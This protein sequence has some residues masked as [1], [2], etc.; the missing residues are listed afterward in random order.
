[1]TTRVLDPSEYHR[2]TPTTLG[3]YVSLLPAETRVIVIEQDGALVGH[4]AVLP[5]W[6][7]EGLWIAPAHRKRGRVLRRLLQGLG[8]TVRDLGIS[9]VIPGADTEEMRTMLQGLGAQPL[10]ALLFALNVKEC[11]SCHPS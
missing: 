6:H 2:L 3:P 1:M 5:M 7:T 4:L 9:T 10:P 8:C 11:P